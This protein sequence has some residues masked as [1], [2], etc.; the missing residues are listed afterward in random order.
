MIHKNKE[1]TAAKLLD[2]KGEKLRQ[3]RS[4]FAWYC[5]Q[6]VHESRG[7]DY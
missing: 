6:A 5:Y 4:V 7:L 1:E 2:A 3:Y